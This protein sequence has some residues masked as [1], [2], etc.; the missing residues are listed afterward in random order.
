MTINAARQLGQ[1]AHI[2]SISVGK[3]A[4]FTL[5]SQDPLEGELRA[6]TVE[7]TWKAG[8][9]VDHRV[10]AWLHPTLVWQ[11]ILAMF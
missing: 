9:P 5:W 1:E 2:G 8:K 11:A 7:E 4:D 10:V 3:Q 6:L